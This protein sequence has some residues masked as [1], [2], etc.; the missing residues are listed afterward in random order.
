MLFNKIY[1]V[2]HFIEAVKKDYP[3]EMEYVFSN[4]FCYWFAK[5]L[6]IRFN[7]KIYFNPRIIHFATLIDNQLFDI[8]GIVDDLDDV[9]YE[10]D[11]YQMTHGVDDIYS[12]CILKD[13]NYE[14]DN[15]NE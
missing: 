14:E 5:I 8:K 2:I 15:K 7:G 6:E 10:W 9:W 4:G 1:E 12:S 3:V 11:E 13:D